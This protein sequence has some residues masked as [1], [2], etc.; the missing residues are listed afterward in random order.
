MH[1]R[2]IA[3]R[4]SAIDLELHVLQLGWDP[5]DVPVVAV[6]AQQLQLGAPG[7]VRWH[8]LEGIILQVQGFQRREA[9]YGRRHLSA[10]L[11]VVQPQRFQT[12]QAPDGGGQRAGQGQQ[13]AR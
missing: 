7:D 13:L 1:F 5:T 8:A 10:Q 4:A 6:D 3:S 9:T 2:S 12:L 11:V